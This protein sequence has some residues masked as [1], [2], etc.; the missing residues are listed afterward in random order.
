MATIGTSSDS[1]S[2]PHIE[3]KVKVQLGKI[4]REL[5]GLPDLPRNTEHEVK[6]S[7][8]EFSEAARQSI[9]IFRQKFNT[10]PSNFRD[11]VIGIHPKFML[12]DISDTPTIDLI[13]SDD[14]DTASVNTP[15]RP[16]KRRNM[17]PPETP[18][19]RARSSTPASQP[20]PVFKRE[21][22]ENGNTNGNTTPGGTP[23]PQVQTKYAKP[24]DRYDNVGRGFRTLAQVRREMEEKARAG[25]PGRIT[26]EVYSSLALEGLKPI[27]LPMMTFLLETQKLIHK[28]LNDAL[29]GSFSG[30]QNR[31]I[32]QECRKHLKAF[33]H[34]HTED[35][36]IH[37]AR[38]YRV[39]TTQITTFDHESLKRFEEAD[40]MTL[41]RYR[42]KQRMIMYGDVKALA[43]K[44][45]PVREWNS[46]SEAERDADT[47]RRAA[48]VQKIGTDRF[49]KE[50][51]VIS[52]VRGY[53]RLAAQRFVDN[54]IQSVF[55]LMI[56]TMK[57]ELSVFLDEQLGL[58]GN[59]PDQTYERLMEENPET[60]A[61]RETL[62]REKAK[63]EQALNSINALKR[64][65][66]DEDD[67][68]QDIAMDGVDGE[69]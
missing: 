2:L 31:V 19:K 39:E 25:M 21:E 36:R 28:E 9:E 40:H 7:L 38:C 18:S 53:Y 30:L 55:C 59:V 67:D 13:D 42:H 46:M 33:L 35:T 68:T 32:F 14:D 5:E 50:I 63:F 20:G 34:K 27:E 26:P 69:V 11:C 60:S 54:V 1:N 43:E 29:K 51:E 41:T 47:K 64:G 23:A 12:R 52:Y 37:M 45:K 3:K 57:E 48:E 56:P 15:T 49:A 24:F 10:L 6:K 44:D 16:S 66:I 62:R 22:S 58:I 61:K 65:D 8:R 4:S 17:A